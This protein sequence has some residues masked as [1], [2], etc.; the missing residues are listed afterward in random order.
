MPTDIWRLDA[1]R[2]TFCCGR[3]GRNPGVD[4]VGVVDVAVAV[5]VAVARIEVLES[6]PC[7]A[8]RDMLWS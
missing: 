4:V 6:G 2:E 3:R 7:W 1:F 8:M 5:A